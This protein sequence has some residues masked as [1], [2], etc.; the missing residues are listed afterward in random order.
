MVFLLIL[1]RLI[2]AAVFGLAAVTK[3][4]DRAGS[5]KAI[6]DFGLTPILA[7]PL[8]ILLPLAELAVALLLLAPQSGLPGG[9]GAAAILIVLTIGIGVNLARGRRPEC[10][11]RRSRRPARRS[12]AAR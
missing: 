11:S 5:R 7:R 3:L 8:S 9:L 10:S 2:L 12:T 1:G 6:E 4:V